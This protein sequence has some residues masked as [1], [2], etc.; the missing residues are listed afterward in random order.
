VSRTGRDGATRGAAVNYEG[1][2]D[3]AVAPEHLG[4]YLR[5]VRDLWTEFGY[6]GAWYG[7]FGQGCVHTR[8]NFELSSHEGL[9]KYRSYVE[10]AADLCVSLADRSRVNTAT[11]RVAVSYSLGCTARE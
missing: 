7:H 6:E 9:Q 5:G 11:D 3:A 4:Q 1:W 2:E 10:R 8:N